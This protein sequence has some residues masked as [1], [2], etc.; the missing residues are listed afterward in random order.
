MRQLTHS[1]IAASLL[2]AS[3]FVLAATSPVTPT[4]APTVPAAAV[5]LQHFTAVQQQ[6]LKQY[7]ANYIMQNPQLI[8][9]SV[10]HMQEQQQMNQIATG[11]TQAIAN[12]AQLVQDK[13]SPTIH[14][15]PVT[16]VEFF[17][18]QCSVC[19]MMQPVVDQFI[20]EHPNVRVVFKSFPI[21]GPASQYAA[22][23]SIAAAMQ[24]SAKFMAFHNAMFKS[25]LME[26]KLKNS[27]VD[28]IAQK[29]GLN[30]SLLKKDMQLPE[31]A[32][33]IKST[34]QLAQKMNLVGTP[35][36][37]MMPTDITNKKMMANIGFIP[38]GTQYAGL[39][40]ALTKISH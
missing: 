30:M 10:Q 25:T 1:L 15:G 26:G 31:V 35:A 6:E 5:P 3:S 37:I 32:A 18:Y 28:T 29:S 12:A 23:V 16:L 22:K 13:Y 36:F 7:L 17:D 14:Q 21:F 8:V 19:H 39:E 34:Y 20:K 38:G 9:A 40:Q 27:N 33:E 4:P 11:R 2:T 24:G